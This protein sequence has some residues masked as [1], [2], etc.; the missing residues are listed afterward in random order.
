MEKWLEV[1]KG[2]L[3]Q[4]DYQSVITH[5]NQTGLIIK[6]ENASTEVSIDFGVI[7]A[8]R[9]L[10]EGMI[11]GELYN[12]DEIKYLKEVGFPNTIYR[13]LDGEYE[14]FIKKIGNEM[15]DYLDMKHYIVVT[16]NH[17]IEVVSEWEPK[18]ILKA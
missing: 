10:D 2:A 5:S 6:L 15:Y 1:F 4:G 17:V 16:S 18:V 13:I 11:L 9:V 3:P 12:E 7:V 14:N 8:F